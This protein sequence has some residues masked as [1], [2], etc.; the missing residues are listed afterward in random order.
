LDSILKSGKMEV[1]FL[2]SDTEWE[3]SSDYLRHPQEQADSRLI[4]STLDA[5]LEIDLSVALALFLR[6]V[7]TGVGAPTRFLELLTRGTPMCAFNGEIM[8]VNTKTYPPAD[9]H[10]GGLKEVSALM[11]CGLLIPLVGLTSVR[12]APLQQGEVLEGISV[13]KANVIRPRSSFGI[14][15]KVKV[16]KVST[17]RPHGDRHPGN[18]RLVT[19]VL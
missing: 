18:Y 8:E 5:E 9:P 6:R 7:E 2:V 17:L 15:H 16:V 10:Y 1:T 19:G 14:T 4:G 11:Q 3:G 12:F 13:L